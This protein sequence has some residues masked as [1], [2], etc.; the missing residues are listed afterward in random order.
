MTRELRTLPTLLRRAALT[1]AYR[2]E[3]GARSALS[4]LARRR[5]WT[6]AVKAYSGYAGTDRARVIAR[7]LLSP[8]GVLPGTQHGLPGWRRLLT[9]EVPGLSAD[10][11]LG[12]E[13]ATTTTDSGGFVD[14]T[15][16]ARLP[17]GL[18][19][20]A[21]TVA[22]R[23][24]ASAHVHVAAPG[25]AIGVVCDVDDTAW[26]TGLTHPLRAAWRTLAHASTGRRAVP[27]MAAL[28]QRVVE[29]TEHAPVLYLS[30]GPWNLA[31]PLSR[32]LERN[33]FPVGAVLMTDWGLSADR[34]LRDGKAHKA[35]S[36]ERLADDFPGVAWVLVG[37]DGEHDPAIYEAF[38]RSHPD[39]VLA[40]ALRQVA[41]RP[42]GTARDQ[43]GAVP[44]LR[45]TDGTVILPELD[46]IL[47]AS[48]EAA[49]GL[50]V[51]PLDSGTGVVTASH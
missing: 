35:G 34:W 44:V 22:G 42:E 30:N 13:R 43:V 3:V 26:I 7:V 48:R 16:E 25:A 12:Q 18:A 20:A 4:A 27:G 40:I 5:G 9:L 11:A 14:T 37:D 24:P 38:V 1:T 47:R 17:P 36:L 19:Q 29:G 23:P 8:A 21:I 45:G 31:G 41:L 2:A 46:A 15:L 50:A 10:V 28:L 51:G 32:F 6:P 39:R 49:A 33:H